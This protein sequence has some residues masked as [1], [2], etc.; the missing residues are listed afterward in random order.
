MRIALKR[1]CVKHMFFDTLINSCK[2]E[3]WTSA[4]KETIALQQLVLISMW[5][6]LS[7]CLLCH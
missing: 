7:H 6:H 2:S 1:V 4:V 3:T 5:F